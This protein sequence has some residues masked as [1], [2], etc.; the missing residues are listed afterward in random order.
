MS[1]KVLVVDDV[2]MNV[3]L[4][5]NRCSPVSVKIAVRVAPAVRRIYIAA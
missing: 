3:K 4:P 2:A 1:A 5:T